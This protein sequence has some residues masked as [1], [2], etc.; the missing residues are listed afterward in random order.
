MG[1]D[2]DGSA[3]LRIEAGLIGEQAQPQFARRAWRASVGQLGEVVCFQHIDAG[4]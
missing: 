3:A 4:A 1:Q 2:V